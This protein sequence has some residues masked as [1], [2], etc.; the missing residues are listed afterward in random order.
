[1]NMKFLLDATDGKI[2][3]IMAEVTSSLVSKRMDMVVS[4]GKSYAT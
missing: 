3:K 2:F 1:M 4:Q